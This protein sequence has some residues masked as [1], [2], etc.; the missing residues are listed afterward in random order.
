MGIPPTVL[1]MTYEGISI[2]RVHDNRIAEVWFISDMMG[3][4]QCLWQ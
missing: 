4:L 3:L 2:F 1:P